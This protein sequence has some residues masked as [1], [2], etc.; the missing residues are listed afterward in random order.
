MAST[1]CLPRISDLPSPNTMETCATFS[2]VVIMQF[3]RRSRHS[4]KKIISDAKQTKNQ[5]LEAHCRGLSFVLVPMI[6]A[7]DAA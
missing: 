6:I 7:V 4:R 3:D 2:A 1:A 5:Q